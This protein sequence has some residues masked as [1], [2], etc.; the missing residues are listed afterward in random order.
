MILPERVLGRS[1]VKITALGRAILP[2]FWPTH[3]RSSPAS[4]SDGSCPPLSSTKHN[5]TWPVCG[6]GAAVVAASAT[7]SWATSADSIS[8]VDRR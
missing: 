3:S 8:V 4:L 6:S 5:G 1:E 2:I 7:A